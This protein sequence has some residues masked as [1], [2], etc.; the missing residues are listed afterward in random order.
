MIP[1]EHLTLKE[2]E[3]K[4]DTQSFLG[5]VLLALLNSLRPE[6]VDS[7]DVKL[8]GTN[9]IA[10]LRGTNV[11]IMSFSRSSF[12]F[13]PTYTEHALADKLPD[14]G[15]FSV[16]EP[17]LFDRTVL[18]E[19]LEERH[20][21]DPVCVVF[22][23]AYFSLQ[24]EELAGAHK[25][26]AAVLVEPA[27]EDADRKRRIVRVH[28]IFQGRDF[29]LEPELCFV[30]MEFKPPY[31]KIYDSLIK[32]TVEGEGLR[33]LK[34]DDIF[35]TTSV[36]EDIWGNINRASLIIAEISSNNPN[37]MYE[38]GICHTVG[39]N[40]MMITQQPDEIPFNF[41]HMRCYAYTNDIPGSD[42][43]KRNIAGVIKHVQATNVA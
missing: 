36:I 39:K 11:V 13:K 9:D 7:R 1:N 3:I 17:A 34:S 19:Y 25:K 23:I 10:V 21:V 6:G 42:E 29:L 16:D 22:P 41:R 28:P 20:F 35:D 31:T 4:H 37:V 30:L 24:G 8:L 18:K 15:D 5:E 38:L 27:K 2:A 26:V 12:V 40:V 32:P 14:K 33:C 43:L